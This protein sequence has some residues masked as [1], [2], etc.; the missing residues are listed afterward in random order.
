[1]NSVNDLVIFWGH[2]STAD[3][4]CF[5]MSDPKVALACDAPEVLQRDSK[6]RFLERD[7]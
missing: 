5:V 2:H 1:M 4:R 6:Y 7:I 3:I